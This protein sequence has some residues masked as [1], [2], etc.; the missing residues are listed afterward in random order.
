MR[1]A[2]ALFRQQRPDVRDDLT[3]CFKAVRSGQSTFSLLPE[4]PHKGQGCLEPIIP[5]GE[6]RLLATPL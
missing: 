5:I 2:T 3:L 1:T 4:Q 6:G